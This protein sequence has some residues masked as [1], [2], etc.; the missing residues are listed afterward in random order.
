MHRNPRQQRF[1]GLFLGLGAITLLCPLIVKADVYKVYG[2]RGSITFTSAKPREGSS[3]EVVDSRI[4]RYRSISIVG[5]YSHRKTW[6]PSVKNSDY[7]PLVLAKAEEFNLE[8]ALVKA[9]VH[10]ESNFNPN[11]TSPKG[12]MGLMQLMPDTARRFNVRN[13][14]HPEQNVTGGAK[15][16]RWLMDRYS[17]NLR[18][19]LAAYNAGEGMVDKVGGI[20]PFR[21]TQQYVARVLQMRELYSCAEKGGGKCKAL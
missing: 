7:D 8:P 12:A 18:L 19:S 16:L 13:A 9:V 10:V 20:P 6:N 5:G 15:Y 2:R 17:G 3:F 14:Y 4:S 11:A 21:E 1:T